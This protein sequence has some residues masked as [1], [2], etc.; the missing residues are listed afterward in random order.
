MPVSR[1]AIIRWLMVRR[2][3]GL[4]VHRLH[5][6]WLRF[7][8]KHFY[9]ARNRR[10]RLAFL[11]HPPR[12]TAV[13]KR[14]LLQFQRSGF[15]H[16]AAADL[17][18]EGA[19]CE[20]LNRAVFEWIRSEAHQA[21]VRRLQE[22]RTRSR[23]AYELRKYP[24]P[25]TR[26]ANDPVVRFGLRTEIL[27]IVNSYLGLMSR[28]QDVSAWH[29]IPF[30][31]HERRIESQRWHRDPEDFRVVKV[32]LLLS[33]VDA[34]AGAT[35]Y[36][37]YSRPGDKYGH[38]FGQN[39]PASSYPGDAALE[40]AVDPCDIVSCDVPAGTIVFLDTVGFHRGGYATTRDRILGFWS[41]TSQATWHDRWFTLVDPP[42]PATVPVEERFA[43]YE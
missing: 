7:T 34:D 23:K 6:A 37:V 43:L 9:A 39:F 19:A 30:G 41:Y 1:P 33:D 10:A 24:I 18:S 31:H 38:L 36:V 17:F 15:A 32:F 21:E 5:N 8:S 13:Q 14:V 29:T 28:M 25:G 26:D 12:L 2:V 16:V 3:I 40:Q 22:S 11:N 42:D 27:D 4:S 20:N 35:E